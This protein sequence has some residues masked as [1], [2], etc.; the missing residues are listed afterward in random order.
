MQLIIG[1]K[2][3]LEAIN[4]GEEI[5]QVFLL[6]GQKGDI[7]NAIVVAAKKKGIKL[8]QLPYDKFTAVTANANS[9]GVA[10]RKSSQK[11]YSVENIITDSK[12]TKYPLLLILDSIQD[13]R[14]LGAILRTAECSGVDG[15]IIT[16]HNSASINETVI[17]TSAG[18]AEHAKICLVNN[19]VNT[20]KVLKDNGF[21]VIG[22]SLEESKDYSSMD[23]KLPAALIIGNEEKGLR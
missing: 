10:A 17:K 16:K 1:R 6:Y 5:E 22:A 15:I 4:S 21:W 19:L 2:P 23:Y 14:N 8:S 9:Q 11:Y 20:I 7:I 18:A 13:P 12:K 3:V